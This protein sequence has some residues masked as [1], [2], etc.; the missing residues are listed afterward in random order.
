[1][2]RYR[3]ARHLA[4]GLTLVVAALLVLRTNLPAQ[5]RPAMAP[6][7]MAQRHA[8]TSSTTTHSTTTT[9]TTS[10]TTTS[11]TTTSTPSCTITISIKKIALTKASNPP[12]EREYHLIANLVAFP[13]P[14][15]LKRKGDSVSYQVAEI[16]TTT[17][18][19]DKDGKLRQVT[20]PVTLMETNTVDDEHISEPMRCPSSGS[21]TV[22]KVFDFANTGTEVS[23]DFLI[24]LDP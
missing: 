12:A 19:G 21:I 1:M 8:T 24:L 15:N 18:V 10:T 2:N 16:I 13:L 23:V 5:L 14:F 4:L 6:E 11:T 17:T 7:V 9:T 3:L 22:T 20:F